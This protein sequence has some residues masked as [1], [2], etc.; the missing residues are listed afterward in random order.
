MF[1]SNTRMQTSHIASENVFIAVLCDKI[2]K[3]KTLTVDNVTQTTPSMQKIQILS[4]NVT[5]KVSNT[6]NLTV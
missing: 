3:Y 2:L 4:N 5:A 6:E 1:L